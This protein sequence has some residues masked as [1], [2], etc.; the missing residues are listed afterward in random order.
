MTKLEKERIAI[1][2]NKGKTY[3]TI[4]N[5]FGIS[6]NTVKSYC[7]RNGLGAK[8]KNIPQPAVTDDCPNCGGQLNHT[9]GAKRKRFCSESC[10]RAWWKAH[11][12][13]V[14]RQAVYAFSCSFCGTAFHSYGNAGR[15]YCS[16]T[17]YVAG[18]FK[19]R[20]VL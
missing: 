13:Y 10:R 4:A 1:L 20:V 3:K 17:C 16:H 6:I 8:R 19:T 7:Q 2:R 14:K 12:E 15:K 9:P 5:E 11:P 18:R